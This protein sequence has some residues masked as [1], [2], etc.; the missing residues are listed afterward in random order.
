MGALVKRHLSTFAG[1]LATMLILYVL[2]TGPVA[3]RYARGQPRWNRYQ[4]IYAPLFWFAENSATVASAFGWYV[5]LWIP[6]AT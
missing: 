2:S 5:N 1:I 6:D 4:E 3:R